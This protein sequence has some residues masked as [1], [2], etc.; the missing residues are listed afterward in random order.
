MRVLGLRPEPFRH[1]KRILG[2]KIMSWEMA[3][4]LFYFIGGSSGILA[5]L[6]PL[7]ND[8]FARDQEKARV[9]LKRIPEIEV[10]ALESYVWFNRY[11][12]DRIFEKFT[13]ITFDFDKKHECVRFSGPIAKYYM[14]NLSELISAYR[15]FRQLVQVSAWEPFHQDGERVWIFKKEVFENSQGVPEGYENHLNECRERAEI[16]AK[17]YKR[18]QITADLHFLEFLFAGILLDRRYEKTQCQAEKTR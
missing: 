17:A 9:L 7:F 16:L 14:R 3:R 8:K 1:T 10:T 6:R 5:F 2:P 15:S 12:P 18:L 13:E 11:V 4:E